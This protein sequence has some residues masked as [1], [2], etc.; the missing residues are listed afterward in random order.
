MSLLVSNIFSAS[1]SEPSSAGHVS[2][3]F[4]S[5]RGGMLGL[6]AQLVLGI[7]VTCLEVMCV[8]VCDC[9]ASKSDSGQV[10]MKCKVV[11]FSPPTNF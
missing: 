4:G 3:R 6:S 7:K 10:A 9:S 2:E 11:F 8:S 5:G 1:V